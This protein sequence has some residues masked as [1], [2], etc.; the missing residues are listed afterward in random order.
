MGFITICRYACVLP[1]VVLHHSG[2]SIVDQMASF[3][4][5]VSKHII[6]TLTIVEEWK[7]CLQLM[8]IEISYMY[9]FL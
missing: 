1:E 5:I 7:V 2:V 4:G 8:E 9:T 3:V 6:S